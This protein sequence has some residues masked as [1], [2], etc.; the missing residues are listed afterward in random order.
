MNYFLQPAVL[1]IM[2]IMGLSSSVY[3]LQRKKYGLNEFYK[4]YVSSGRFVTSTS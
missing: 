2:T 3:N 4:N 1:I